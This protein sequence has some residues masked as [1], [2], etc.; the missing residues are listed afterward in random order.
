MSSEHVTTDPIELQY[1]LTSDDLS[2][3]VSA[4]D[5]HALRPWLIPVLSLAAVAVVSVSNR[6][7]ELSVGAIVAVLAI[8]LAAV[9]VVSGISQ[10]LVRL[11]GALI[12]RWQVRLILRA[13][14]WLSQPIRASVTDAGL[15]LSNATEDSTIG[16]RQY[17]LFVETDRSFVM[18]ASEKRS[19][20]LLVLP[21][22]GLVG[23]APEQLRALLATHSRKRTPRARRAR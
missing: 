17:P 4:L 14:P 7:W 16:W 8:S 22:R 12:D 15:H 3:G 6:L 18:L 5:R 2:D 11:L 13:N 9:L 21:K 10:V 19:A 1:T 23:A 20:A